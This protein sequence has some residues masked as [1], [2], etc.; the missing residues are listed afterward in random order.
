MPTS[1]PALK[2]IAVDV[3][4]PVA[5][6]VLMSRIF[7][8]FDES[9]DARTAATKVSKLVALFLGTNHARELA[10]RFKPILG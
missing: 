8:V 3:V 2:Q 6:K 10:E 7:S 4:G 5:S 9:P 1:T